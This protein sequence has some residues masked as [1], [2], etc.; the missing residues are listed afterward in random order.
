MHP[1]IIK[2]DIS[3]FKKSVDCLGSTLSQ[4]VMDHKRLEFIFRKKHASHIHAH[5]SRHTHAYHAHT[6]D[7]LYANVYICTHCGRKSH[8]TKFCYDRINALN[9]ASKNV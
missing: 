9:F 1:S 8:L 3:M 7:S 5:K 2:N 6:H 4:C